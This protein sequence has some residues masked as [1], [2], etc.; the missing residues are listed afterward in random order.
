MERLLSLSLWSKNADTHD[1]ENIFSFASNLIRAAGHF[2]LSKLQFSQK[3]KTFWTMI[4]DIY[5]IEE[6]DDYFLQTSDW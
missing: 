5:I 6:E 3:N 1:H 4:A 2:L